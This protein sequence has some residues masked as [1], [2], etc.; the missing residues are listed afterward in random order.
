M[1]NIFKKKKINLDGDID[2][3]LK[4]EKFICLGVN[5]LTDLTHLESLITP[6]DLHDHI[7]KKLFTIE[8]IKN[9]QKNLNENEIPYKEMLPEFNWISE[10][11]VSDLKYNNLLSCSV[12]SGVHPQFEESVEHIY[13][14]E[15]IIQPAIL[16]AI[17]QNPEHFKEVLLIETDEL[18]EKGII[19]PLHFNSYRITISTIENTITK[20]KIINYEINCKVE[21]SN[22]EGKFHKQ[23]SLMEEL[24]KKA[25]NGETDFEPQETDLINLLNDQE[26]MRSEYS[27]ISYFLN[28]GFINLKVDKIDRAEQHFNTIIELNTDIS[29]LTLGKDFLRPIGEFYES[30]N[31]LDKALYWYK[32]ATEFNPNVG[33]KKKIKE[34]E[35]ST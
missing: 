17:K 6:L 28:L 9:I 34:L 19:Y 22:L 15:K 3:P 35:T 21:P 29:K 18:F 14:Y 23:N 26:T 13:F 20:K 1:F 12:D 16:N 32:K 30:K 5:P 11:N 25:E 31:N 24:D 7:K 10:N 33:L 4:V 27:Q 8:D 2:L